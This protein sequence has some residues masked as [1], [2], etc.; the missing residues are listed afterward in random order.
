[1][2]AE[3]ATEPKYTCKK[4]KPEGIRTLSSLFNVCA[5]GKRVQPSL[6]YT[7]IQ[8]LLETVVGTTFSTS[9]FRNAGYQN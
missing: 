4:L 7:M 5:D 8:T 9:K 3:T 2:V 1:M 6:Q